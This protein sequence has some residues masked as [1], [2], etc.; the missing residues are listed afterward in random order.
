[1]FTCSKGCLLRQIPCQTLRP[2]PPM[3]LCAF[4]SSLP[5]GFFQDLISKNAQI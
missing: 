3:V 5:R 1:M 2:S 4:V